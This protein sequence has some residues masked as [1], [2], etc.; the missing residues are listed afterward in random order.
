[1]YDSQIRFWQVKDYSLVQYY[2]IGQI[3]LKQVYH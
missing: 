1:M 3:Y 2:A